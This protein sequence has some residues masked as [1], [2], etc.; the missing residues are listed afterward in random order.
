MTVIISTD[1][2]KLHET[3]SYRGC[4]PCLWVLLMNSNGLEVRRPPLVLDWSKS[5]L[6]TDGKVKKMLRVKDLLHGAPKKREEEKCLKCVLC[7]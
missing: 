7:T 1:S 5:L 3:S 6:K 4:Y 2:V